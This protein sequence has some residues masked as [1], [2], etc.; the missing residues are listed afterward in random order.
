MS[1]E[2][3]ILVQTVQLA[4]ASGGESVEHYRAMVILNGQPAA[5][6]WCANT[7]EVKQDGVARG[8][9]I[10]SAQRKFNHDV[11]TQDIRHGAPPAN[12]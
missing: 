7:G 8:T 11:L 10:A 1:D 5:E 3:Y 4:P 2:L 9:A 6:G 12:C